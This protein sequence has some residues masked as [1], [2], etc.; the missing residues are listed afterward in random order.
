MLTPKCERAA[1]TLH[2]TFV[3]FLVGDAF[4]GSSSWHILQTRRPY[5]RLL[6]NRL[7]RGLDSLRDSLPTAAANT[8]CRQY[9]VLTCLHASQVYMRVFAAYGA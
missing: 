4:F 8:T 6:N 2:I 7:R 1:A 9:N 3:Q 5:S